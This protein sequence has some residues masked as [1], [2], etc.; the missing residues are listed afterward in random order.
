MS[1]V[2]LLVF[3]L[4]ATPGCLGADPAPAEEVEPTT[5]VD[6]G[7]VLEGVPVAWD[8]RSRPMACLPRGPGECGGIAA[9]NEDRE[10]LVPELGEGRPVSFALTMTWT[11]SG[12]LTER[13]A[14][15][16]IGVAECPHEC[17]VEGTS[18]L[19]FEMAGL[20]LEPE[21]NLTFHVFAPD[22]CHTPCAGAVKAFLDVG[23]DVVVDGNIT[24]ERWA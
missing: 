5:V 18:P 8:G 7:P 6:P 21:T 9:P 22:P 2:L 15:H 1:R 11:P 19:T 17:V 3:A 4:A 20:T 24:V 16:A 10:F 23:Q 13:M 12:P 14:L